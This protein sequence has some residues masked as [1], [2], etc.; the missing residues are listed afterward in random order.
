MALTSKLS[1]IGDAIRAKTGKSEQ[2]TLEQM[3]TEIASIQTGGEQ[4]AGKIET[5][6]FNSEHEK[7]V[8]LPENGMY[9]AMIRGTCSPN[10][11]IY[12]SNVSNGTSNSNSCYTQKSA[13][14]ESVLCVVTSDSTTDFYGSVKGKSN[15]KSTTFYFHTYTPSAVFTGT[16]DI[17]KV[18]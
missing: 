1:A 10:D 11:Y 5:I 8:S 13:T 16:I 17:Y 4:T 15:A 2:M 7:S 18:I 3:V 6:N 9:L 12:M 14:I